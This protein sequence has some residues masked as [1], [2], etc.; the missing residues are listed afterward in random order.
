MLHSSS[1]ESIVIDSPPSLSHP[2]FQ[3]CRHRSCCECLEP[4]SP[5]STSVSPVGGMSDCSNSEL[6]G[7]LNA[8]RV[9]WE[10][11]AQRG[12]TAF[13]SS[14]PTID[15]WR[16]SVNT[17]GYVEGNTYQMRLASTAQ[18]NATKRRSTYD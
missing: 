1:S 13:K 6:S 10:Q 3:A 12:R 14:H 16:N 18:P 9:R 7:H 17:N 11:E 2:T 5:T 8:L 4:S 15:D